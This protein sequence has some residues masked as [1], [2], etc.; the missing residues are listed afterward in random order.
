MTK[1]V[2]KGL[3]QYLETFIMTAVRCP[4][5][6]NLAVVGAEQSTVDQEQRTAPGEVK[7]AW[8]RK[9]RGTWAGPCDDLDTCLD[10]RKKLLKDGTKR[11][12]N[13]SCI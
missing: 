1:A 6:I 2:C 8:H 9:S 4:Q 5:P 10:Q 12:A 7:W 3:K 13:S 11:Y